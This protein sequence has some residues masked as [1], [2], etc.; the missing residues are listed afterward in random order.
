MES[1]ASENDDPITAPKGISPEM[2]GRTE[3]NPMLKCFIPKT[4]S[5]FER[6]SD[7]KAWF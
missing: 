5:F 7:E 3:L 6:L 4:L 1:F 2:M